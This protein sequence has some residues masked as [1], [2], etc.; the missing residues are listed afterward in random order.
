MRV[1]VTTIVL[2]LLLVLGL[3]GL[4]M[5]LASSTVEGTS[6]GNEQIADDVKAEHAELAAGS[7]VNEQVLRSWGARNNIDKL[8]TDPKDLA[9]VLKKAMSNRRTVP[10][11][12]SPVRTRLI[13]IP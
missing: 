1:K 5:S 2:S 4:S 11:P 8:V 12:T 13:P 7:D 10:L 6:H 3:G 9:S